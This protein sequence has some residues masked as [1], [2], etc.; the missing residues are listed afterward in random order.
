MK[1][2]NKYSGHAIRAKSIMKRKLGVDSKGQILENIPLQ[3]GPCS[4]GT[5]YLHKL[6]RSSP[7]NQVI[8][9]KGLVK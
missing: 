5:N 2:V 1:A 6:Y 9:R 3:I 8:L 4:P 7:V